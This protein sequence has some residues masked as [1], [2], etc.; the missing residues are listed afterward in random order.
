[1]E[2][3][4]MSGAS[5]VSVKKLAVIHS[6]L[7]HQRMQMQTQT[8]PSLTCEQCDPMKVSY[9]AASALTWCTCRRCKSESSMQLTGAG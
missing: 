3:A 6:K 4:I 5:D 1:M 7:S 2:T 8:Q 9:S